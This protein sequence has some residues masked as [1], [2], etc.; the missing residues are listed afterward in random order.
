MVETFD[1]AALL[2]LSN[3]LNTAVITFVIQTTSNS[4][5]FTVY[6]DTLK[7]QLFVSA[8]TIIDYRHD[9]LEQENDL[10]MNENVFAED[11]LKL[12]AKWG[13][14]LTGKNKMTYTVKPL[15]YSTEK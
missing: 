8:G 6:N 10:N 7:R 3:M 13:I 5:G 1:E 15:V 4:F 2:Q 11:I 9:P 14:D 12:A